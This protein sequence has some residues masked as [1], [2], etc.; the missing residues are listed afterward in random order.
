MRNLN[1]ILPKDLEVS[2]IS[3]KLRP[4]NDLADFLPSQ[5]RI[6]TQR[7]L[8][9]FHEEIKAESASYT[10]ASLSLPLLP[11][12][13]YGGAIGDAWDARGPQWLGHLVSYELGEPQHAPLRQP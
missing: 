7:S 1:E 13:Q 8:H 3:L 12:A 9:Q 4:T 10:L 5:S 6:C 11:I 2:L